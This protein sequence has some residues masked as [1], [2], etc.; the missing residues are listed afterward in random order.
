M[1][2][3]LS[4]YECETVIN[5]NDESKEA[6]VYTCNKSM[7]NRLTKLSEKFPDVFK[8]QSEDEHSKTYTFPKNLISIRAPK[9][10]TEEQRLKM[11][12]QARR[13]LGK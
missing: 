12:E 13:N 5:Y 1:A 10:L 6:T 8:L 3:T 2:Y 9:V 11:Q 7:K 4:K